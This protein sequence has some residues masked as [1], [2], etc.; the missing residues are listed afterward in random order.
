MNQSPYEEGRRW[1]LQAQQD[2]DDAQYVHA[3]KRFNLACFLAQ[4]A[5]EKAIKGFLYAQGWRPVI[6]CS[7]AKL[8]QD[9]A[10]FDAAFDELRPQAAPLDKYY[11]PTRYPNGLPGG[12]PAEAFD[13]VDAN[14]ALELAHHVLQFVEGRFPP[15]EAA[16]ADARG[17]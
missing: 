7:V 15:P 16:P 3:G 5:A 11:V 13:Q 10:T 8:C 14:R 4:Q 1:L 9:A 17:K 6:G 2:V 12:I